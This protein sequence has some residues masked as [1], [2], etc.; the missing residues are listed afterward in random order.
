MNGGMRYFVI[1]PTY[2]GFPD[3]SSQ[4]VAVAPADADWYRD[5]GEWNDAGEWAQTPFCV[6]GEYE[7]LDAA[8]AAHPD[9]N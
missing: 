5:G 4:I 8:K 6:E 9:A 1:T 3:G 2:A 7:S